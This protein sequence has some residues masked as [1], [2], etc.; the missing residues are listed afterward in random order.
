[1]ARGAGGGVARRALLA[2]GGEN[3]ARCVS[4]AVYMAV[5]KLGCQA[6]A[7]VP[8]VLAVRV[9]GSVAKGTTILG[10]S[11]IDVVAIIADDLS[12]ETEAEAISEM[13]RRLALLRRLVPAFVGHVNVWTR[14]HLVRNAVPLP[15]GSS[16]ADIRVV[17]GH[18]WLPTSTLNVPACVA[19]AGTT[20]T[21]AWVARAGDVE[22]LAK[23]VGAIRDMVAD[24]EKRTDAGPSAASAAP[25]MVR[26]L[27]ADP[28]AALYAR[29]L[30]LAERAYELG[31][32]RIEG[33]FAPGRYASR[34]DFTGEPRTYVVVE[35]ADARAVAPALEEA[36]RRPGVHVVTDGAQAPGHDSPRDR[37]RLA[38][39]TLP[40]HGHW[41]SPG[42]GD[43]PVL[44]LATPRAHAEDPDA[45]RPGPGG[46]VPHGR[47]GTPLRRA[48]NRRH[49]TR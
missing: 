28:V 14:A 2:L 20:R 47:R 8:G 24:T 37:G 27:G 40:R 12:R 18:L 9:K 4:N 11:D 42:A 41:T 17:A 48:R 29:G 16:L 35:S 5:A 32:D 46:D 25:V 49:D 39:E 23:T 15:P 26:G 10:L 34:D 43:D 30:A 22:A 6:I 38:Q 3:L 31:D 21:L 13:L 1:V 45:L 44:A 19:A 33:G 7:H 36:L